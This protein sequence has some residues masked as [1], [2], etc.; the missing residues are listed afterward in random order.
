[1]AAPKENTRS[2]NDHDEDYDDIP[3]QH[4]R[5]FGAGLHKR[6]ISFVSASTGSSQLQSVNN[7][8]PKLSP[9]QD[10]SDIYLN[11]VLPKTPQPSPPPPSESQ[12]DAPPCPI[13][14][15]PLQAPSS[16]THPPSQCPTPHTQ[17]LA[18]QLSLPHSHPPS[19]LD[20]TRMGLSYLSSHGWDP[21]ARRGLGAAEQ[22]IAFPVKARLKDDNRGVGMPVSV[23]KKGDE[24]GRGREKEKLLDAGKVRKLVKEEGRR[25]ERV[26]EELFGDGR[27][28]KY[29]GKGA[30][31]GG[32]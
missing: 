1:M 28:E 17:S 20:R 9:P 24:K 15:L 13:C 11:L 6:P 26:W 8:T 3:L 31:G 16:P 12:P 30:G 4:Q 10:I 21:D 2:N 14:N 19:S 32:S 5:Y 27:V 25:R 23:S 29:L 7:T 18:H 22:G